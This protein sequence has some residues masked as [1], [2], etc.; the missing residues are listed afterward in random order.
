MPKRPISDVGVADTN[1]QYQRLPSPKTRRQGRVDSIVSRLTVAGGGAITLLP[2]QIRPCKRHVARLDTSR[3]DT[4]PVSSEGN[5]AAARRTKGVGCGVTIDC[6]VTGAGKTYMAVHA[7]QVLQL[8]LVVVA[9]LAT[10]ATWRSMQGKFDVRVSSIMTYASLAGGGCAPLNHPWLV[11]YASPQNPRGAYF[12]TEYMSSQCTRGILLVVDE[13]HRAKNVETSTH[14]AV[15]AMV[16]GIRKRGG[17]VMFMSATPIDKT[18][19]TVAMMRLLDLYPPLIVTE[20]RP[21]HAAN[22]LRDRMCAFLGLRKP[23]PERSRPAR[24][25]ADVTRL[26]CQYFQKIVMPMLSSIAVPDYHPGAT[27]TIRN[28]HITF[29]SSE[30]RAL[31]DRAL[32]SLRKA[33]RGEE[34]GRGRHTQSF[35][36]VTLALKALSCSKVGEVVHMAT[37]ILESKPSSK[38][39]IFADYYETLDAVASLLSPYHPR[40]V[41]GRDPVTMRDQAINAFQQPSTVCRVLIANPKCG[42][43]GI[44]L[45][46]VT[47]RF[48][49]FTLMLPSFHINEMVQAIGRTFRVGVRGIATTWVIYGPKKSPETTLMSCISRKGAIMSSILH[50]QGVVFPDKYHAISYSNVSWL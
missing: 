9:P 32:T 41:T 39:V 33:I 35:G 28:M 29:S 10:H 23:Y 3:L 31:Y 13:F 34:E 49:R 6:S 46:D 37:R 27:H 42:G 50:D 4:S 43:I 21:D 25:S 12:P 30:E 17:R 18:S 44:S 20:L 7:A 1:A 45:H 14:R 24:T 40:M 15:R 48:P 5:K 2:H 26:G 11:R 8:D 22:E 47:G 36:P 38:V 19:Q 16:L